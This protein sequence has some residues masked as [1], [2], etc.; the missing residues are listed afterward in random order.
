MGNMLINLAESGER[1]TKAGEA[2]AE[3]WTAN[4]G[5][6]F[7]IQELIRRSTGWIPAQFAKLMGTSEADAKALLASFG[8]KETADGKWRIGDDEL[9]KLMA[10]NM[11]LVLSYP[12]IDREAFRIEVQ[13][14]LDTFL[15]T[16]EAP[17]VDWERITKL[18]LDPSWRPNPAKTSDAVAEERSG[19]VDSVF[20][21]LVNRL[22]SR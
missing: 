15:K 21:R 22:L 13:E 10:D 3:D 5:Q 6:P 7:K 8:A 16:G 14:R 9:S 1:A 11:T 18:P 2:R 4:G 19:S 12:H 20:K 17:E